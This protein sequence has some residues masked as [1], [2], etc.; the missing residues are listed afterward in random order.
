M[1]VKLHKT[2][3]LMRLTQIKDIAVDLKTYSD[4]DETEDVE[5]SYR[6]L[7]EVIGKLIDDVKNSDIE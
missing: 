3:I 2:D 6:F 1:E 4:V 5:R 7:M